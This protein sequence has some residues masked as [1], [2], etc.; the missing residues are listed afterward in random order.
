MSAEQEYGRP[1]P[2]SKATA[3]RSPEAVTAARTAR[4][5]LAMSGVRAATDGLEIV[6]R[7]A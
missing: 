4:S 1:E 5:V 7:D 2:A 6:M 3:S